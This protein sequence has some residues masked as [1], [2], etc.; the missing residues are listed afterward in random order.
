MDIYNNG[1]WFKCSKEIVR[2]NNISQSAKWLY[3]VLSCLNNQFGKEKGF[4]TRTN[5]QLCYDANL[6]SGTLKKAKNELID[7]GYIKVWHNQL[8][9]D[10]EIEKKTTFRIC[11][12]RILK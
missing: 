7:N 4:F 3:V 1:D 5:N 11:Y 10:K 12:I 6:S 9:Q 8:W 2:D